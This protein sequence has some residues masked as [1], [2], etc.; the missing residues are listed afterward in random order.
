MS[1][2]VTKK[3]AQTIKNFME[4]MNEQVG[5]LYWEEQ[6]MSSC[7]SQMLNDLSENLALF[8]DF[9]NKNVKKHLTMHESCGNINS[10]LKR[11]R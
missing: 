10:K 2:V 1:I 3:Q 9:L 6:R 8:A 5:D 7:G 4:E 11:K